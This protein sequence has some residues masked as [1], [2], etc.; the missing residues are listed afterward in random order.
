MAE[1]NI[2]SDSSRT[3]RRSQHKYE[4]RACACLWTEPVSS[5]SQAFH[6]TS[7]TS[8]VVQRVMNVPLEPLARCP[9][10]AREKI[11]HLHTCN[12]LFRYILSD[13]TFSN[14]VSTILTFTK[15]F[16]IKYRN[17]TPNAQNK[18]SAEN[19]QASRFL[20]CG[21]LNDSLSH[22]HLENF[23]L[24]CTT[25]QSYLLEHMPISTMTS[26]MY[27]TRSSYATFLEQRCSNCSLLIATLST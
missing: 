19:S 21:S 20:H 6:I 2:Y 27:K 12:S 1:C 18:S 16:Q 25:A 23:I 5:S 22:V 24:G 8:L 10:S 11:H 26:L 13:H 4:R 7:L 9:F 17:A 15:T 14:T 3:V